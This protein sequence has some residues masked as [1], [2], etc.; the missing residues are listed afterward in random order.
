MKTYWRKLIIAIVMG[1]ALALVFKS[2][3][4]GLAIFSV[5]AI[6]SWIPLYLNYAHDNP[7]GLWFKRKLFGWGWTPVTWQ[8][9]LIVVLYAVLV[10]L[11]A[12]TLNEDSPPRE[13]AFTF[14]LPIAI[15][16]TLLIRICYRKGEKP[17]WQWGKDI[18]KYE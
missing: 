17:R 6:V 4:I 18:E 9:W 14:L 3:S 10:S 15:L 1:I 2:V 12:L 8:G 7:K 5:I 11:F 13:V 16:T